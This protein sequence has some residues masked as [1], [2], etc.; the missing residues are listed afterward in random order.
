M[1]WFYWNKKK[2]NT[3][4]L[5]SAILGD[6]TIFFFLFHEIPTGVYAILCFPTSSCD[7]KGQLLLL[8][9]YIY[10]YKVV[11]IAFWLVKSYDFTSQNMHYVLNQLKKSKMGKIELKSGKIIKIAQNRDIKTD[12]TISIELLHW[13]FFSPNVHL[14]DAY[15]NLFFPFTWLFS[16]QSSD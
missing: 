16:L 8:L 1:A 9:I 12:C 13:K 7:E 11:K 14:S 4:V 10:I 15:W 3:C 2:E 6:M 5:G